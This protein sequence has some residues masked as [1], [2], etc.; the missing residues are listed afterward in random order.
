GRPFAADLLAR[1]FPPP[2]SR[3]T[4][5]AAGRALGLRVKSIR[6]RAA[7]VERQV[8]PLVV[9]LRAPAAPRPGNVHPTLGIVT[10][11]AERRVVLFRAGT[12]APQTLPLEEFAALHDGAAWLC[13]PQTE[14][15]NDPD[16]AAAAGGAG[17]TTSRFSFRWFV[18][19]LLKHRRVWRDVLLASAA[20]QIVALA[21]PLFTQAIIDKVVVHRTQS[22]LIAIG[23]AMAV[24]MLFTT[25]LTWV[26]QYLVLHTGNRVD[27]V[28]G[29]AVW[30]HLLRLPLRYFEHRPTG[31]VAARLHGVETIREFVSGAAVSLVLDLPFLL[32]CLGVMFWYSATLTAIALGILTV[33][34]VASLVVAPVFQAR[35]NEQFLLGARNQAFVTEHIAGLETV[36]SL[37]MEPQLRQRYAQYLAAFLQSGFRTRQIANTYNVL[38]ST[39]EQAMTLL[40]LMMGAWIVMTEPSFTIGMLVAFQMFAGK[41]SQPVLRIVG[42]WTQ[43]QQARLSVERLGDVMNAPIEPYSLTPQRQSAGRG[44]IEIEGLAFRYADDRPL[45]YENLTLA[46]EP[47]QAVAMM[48]PSGSGK[49]TLAKLMLGFYLPTAGAIRFDGVDAR[50]LAANELRAAFGVV[51]QETIL[52]SGTILANLSAGNPA[53]SFEQVAQACRM[54]G[55]HDVIEALP[56]GY[57]TEVGERGVGLSGGQKQRLAIARALLKGPKVLIFDEATSALDGE[58]AENFARTINALKGKVTMLFI[59]HALPRGLKVDRVVQLGGKGGRTLDLAATAQAQSA[60]QP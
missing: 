30:E 56:Q 38:A 42:L 7:A 11:A 12:N 35:L 3:T 10:A 54:A 17:G 14:A 2:C 29:A 33:I 4:I 59:A 26:R 40:I 43:F 19:E 27:A 46:I 18:P 39:L 32:I 44:R 60:S 21:T 37:Q 13:A 23:V 9:G 48:G 1:E 24:F 49:S 55:I 31:V 22:T 16:A 57:Q 50:H 52:F 6:L 15:A 58:T 36:K 45:L 53:A 28:L 47:G 41:L 20:L 34:A 25:L 8:F 51:P 5:V